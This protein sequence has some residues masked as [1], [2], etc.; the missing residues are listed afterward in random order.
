MA[1]KRQLLL[2]YE[3]WQE[4]ENSSFAYVSIIY[5]SI[6]IFNHSFIQQ[7]LLSASYM[8]GIVGIQREVKYFP[9]S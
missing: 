4:C 8:P 2:D 1:V 3:S 5:Q 7:V 9:W 6:H